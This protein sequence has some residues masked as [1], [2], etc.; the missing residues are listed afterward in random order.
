[1]DREDSKTEVVKRKSWGEVIDTYF[2]GRKRTTLLK[3]SHA[4][5]TRPYEDVM[6][7]SR[8]S[9]LKLRQQSFYYY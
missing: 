4:S 8:S 6:A 7:V 9:S 3:G 1:M 5:P 2:G